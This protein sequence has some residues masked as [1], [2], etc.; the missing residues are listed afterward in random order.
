MTTIQ[1][2]AA[3]VFWVSV[4]VVSYAYFGYPIVLLLCYVWAQLRR[5]LRFLAGR[6]ER[7]VRG[8]LD[9]EC[10]AVSFVIAA[11]NEEAVL[12]AKLRNLAALDYPR[13]KLEVLFV[14]DA[15]DDGTNQI[16]AAS[17]EVRLIVQTVRSGKPAAL[18]VGVNAASNEILVLS[19]AATLLAP[20]ALRQLVR[21]FADPKVGAVCG[22]LRFEANTES[23]QT[24]GVYW[25]YE[26]MLRLMEARLGATLTAS[27]ALYAM[28]RMAFKPFSPGTLIEDLI[29]PM[30]VRDAGLSVVYDPEAIATDVAA[31]SVSGEF[32]R[33]VRIARGS[34]RALGQ[35]CRLRLPSFT[36][37]AFVSHKVLR[38]LVGH[39]GLLI[40]LSNLFLL[41][42]RVYAILFAAH[43]AL[44]GWAAIGYLGRD[45]LRHVRFAL[46]GYFLF[47]MNL[48]FLIGFAGSL[49]ASKEGTWQ[50]AN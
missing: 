30:N 25:K 38:W 48:A 32:R 20:D 13:Q 15:S 35:I 39:F 26:S 33:R 6:R 49:G 34:F 40:L 42:Y 44:L 50:R 4:A 5:D 28:R 18:N 16:L 46:L 27:G 14:S 17:A 37:F 2:I 7:R 43:S 47:A 45:R 29:A 10:P 31:D 22:A 8:L 11:Y 9:C 21:H 24:E 41:E 1:T 12:P 23:R 19:D 36:M 3:A